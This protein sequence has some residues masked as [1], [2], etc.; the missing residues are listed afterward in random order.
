M[1]RHA[2]VVVAIAG[3][4]LAGCG[5]GSSKKSSFDQAAATAG[6]TTAYTSVF[7]N[8]QGTLDQKIGYIEDGESLRSFLVQLGQTP[9]GKAKTS[10]KDVV[11]T[12]PTHTTAAVKFTII[13]GGSPFQLTGKAVL[14][15]G[16]WKVAKDTFCGLSSQAVGG[17]LP[18]ACNTK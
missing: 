4:L 16:T 5:G 1:R 12:F 3:V 2:I 15:N 14:Q 7:T 13:Y 8:G 10:I 6:V 18:A 11:V 9:S 17:K